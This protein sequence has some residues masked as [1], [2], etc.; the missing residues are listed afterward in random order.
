MAYLPVPPRARESE[1]P[2]RA[3]ASGTALGHPR[4]EDGR[5]DCPV[6]HR[7]PD[8]ADKILDLLVL[9]ETRELVDMQY[10]PFPW[11]PQAIS[12]PSTPSTR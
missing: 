7:A 12:T 5:P 3:P 6:R 4:D 8:K 11:S 2:G 9:D 1:R 10:T